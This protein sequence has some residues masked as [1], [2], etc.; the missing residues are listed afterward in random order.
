MK[1]RIIRFDT[2][3]DKTSSGLLPSL[4]LS[5]LRLSLTVAIVLL[6]LARHPPSF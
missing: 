3:A 5:L 6:I 4:L 1:A 2:W